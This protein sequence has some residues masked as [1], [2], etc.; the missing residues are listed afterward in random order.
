MKLVGM[1]EVYNDDDIIEELL[2]FY[3]SQGF[4]LVVLDN[5]STDKT[6]EI[7]QRFQNKGIV[8]LSRYPSKNWDYI[9]D[10]QVL[11]DMAL[12]ESPD[13]VIRI[14]SDEFFESGIE[15]ETLKEAISKV[16]SQGFNLIQSNW[17]Q[18]YLTDN[19]NDSKSV[20]K[21][22]RYYSWTS[23]YLYRAWKVY[24]GI[25]VEAGGS[26]YPVFPNFLKYKIYPKKF[27]M[28]HYQFRSVKQA[29]KKLADRLQKIGD[30]A[31]SILGWHNRYKIFN[32]SEFPKII[33]HKLL[34]RCD[35][36]HHWNFELKMLPFEPF[37]NHPK[38]RRTFFP[39]W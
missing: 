28:R 39:R 34:T 31:E 7:C 30:N 33:N 29:K 25:L 20:R 6:Y 2:N 21:R 35:E 10:L 36:D 37:P 3:I 18:F 1:L 17:F 26:H 9:R 11:Y 23:D 15:N 16:D 8:R 19:D 4:D 32:D 13:W 24:P 5:G 38:K 27:V 14:D 22:M 12:M